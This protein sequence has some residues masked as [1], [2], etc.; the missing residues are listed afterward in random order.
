MQT[1]N[2]FTIFVGSIML[3]AVFSPAFALP[4]LSMQPGKA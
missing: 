1:N 2:F 4:A 3:L